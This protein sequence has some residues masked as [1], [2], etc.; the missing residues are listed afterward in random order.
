[1]PLFFNPEGPVNTGKHN[2]PHWQQGEVPIFI[3][4]RLAD[5][6]PKAKLDDWKRGKE[7]FNEN[8]PKPW[9]DETQIE[10]RKQFTDEMEA[11]LDRGL[12]E[13]QLRNA[14]IRLIVAEAL[15]H[16]HNARYY[17][18]AFVIMPNHLHVLLTPILPHLLADILHSL[19]S[20]T[21]NKINKALTR[22][23]P[24]WMRDYHDRLIRSDKHYYWAQ[25]YIERN[26]INLPA[27][28]LTL[29]KASE[30][31]PS[32]RQHS[33]LHP[34]TAKNHDDAAA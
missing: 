22:S 13:C 21:S 25:R 32:R 17:L 2:L 33:N 24:F 20:F 9:D 18:H 4:F 29:W 19:K 28:T 34:T 7:Q 8:H 6:L 5:S 12:G 26:P 3:T 31:R 27:N 14:E 16:F 23:G 1:M 15:A 10:Y 11:W 30:S